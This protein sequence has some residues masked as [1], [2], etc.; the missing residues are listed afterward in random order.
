MINL[1]IIERVVTVQTWQLSVDKKCNQIYSIPAGK[2]KM[3]N[4]FDK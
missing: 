2:A 3:I 4:N 1:S